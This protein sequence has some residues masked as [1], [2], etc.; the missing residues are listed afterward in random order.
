M[1]YIHEKLQETI[2]IDE[3]NL[4]YLQQQAILIDLKVKILKIIQADTTLMENQKK[5]AV[6]IILKLIRQNDVEGLKKFL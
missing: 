1:S 3:R 4:A 5:E 2:E 6:K